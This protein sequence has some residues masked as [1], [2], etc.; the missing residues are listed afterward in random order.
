MIP[1]VIHYCWFG[2]KPLPPMAIKC[3]NSWKK[4]LPDFEI[5]EWNEKNFNISIIPYTAEAYKKKKYAFVSDY[6]RFWILYNYGG[7]YFDTDVEII[8]S[9]EPIITK[10]AFLGCENAPEQESSETFVNPG[11]GMASPPKLQI[12]KDILDSYQADRFTKNGSLNLTTI[13]TRTTNILKKHGLHNSSNIQQIECLNIYPTEYF[14]PI[15][16]VTKEKKVT[17]N[18]YTIHHFAAS[19]VSEYDNM[20]FLERFWK[21]CHLPNTNI[22]LKLKKLFHF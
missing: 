9:L 8:Q 2:K 6:A 10:G 22:R 17:S 18:T 13:V 4:F 20:P 15:N 16:Y 19:W 21:R 7:I 1:K 3:I 11:L 5:K 12:F 14:C